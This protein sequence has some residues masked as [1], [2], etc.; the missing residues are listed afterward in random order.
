MSDGY[1]IATCGRISNV[2]ETSVPSYRT[3]L[4]VSAVILILPAEK[5]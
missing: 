2:D 1:T 3:L 5:V 4:A